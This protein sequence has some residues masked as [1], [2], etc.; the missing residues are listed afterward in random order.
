MATRW[1][2]STGRS[3]CR[4]DPG[5]ILG[6]EHAA[7]LAR[8]AGR[9]AGRRADTRRGAAL[10]GAAARRRQAADPR[11]ASRGRAR[12]VHR[13]RRR[14]A[15]SWPATVLEQAARERAAARACRRA[16]A[17]PPAARLPRPRAPAAGASHGVR[18]PARVR[19]GRG[20]RHA[21]VGR[22]PP[23]D[24]RGQRAGGDRRAHARG[25]ARCSG[26]LCAGAPRG[27][28]R[29][30]CAATS[31]PASSASSAGPRVGRAAR[32]ARRGAVCGRDR[33]ARAG[34]RV[35]RAARDRHPARLLD[36]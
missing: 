25:A 1:R 33:H 8:A 32:G 20:R 23:G 19:S 29:R 26:T 7:E 24:A 21:A 5:A 34:A 2:C 11:G 30:C 10:G 31:W 13:P 28:P 22:R 6:E 35:S 17:Q 14:A 3:S 9:A 27:R 4:L 36:G 15:P 12:D 16:G 18:L